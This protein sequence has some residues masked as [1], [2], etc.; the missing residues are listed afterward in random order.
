M[1]NVQKKFVCMLFYFVSIGLFLPFGANAE[2]AEV[3]F[4]NSGF[5]TGDFT[6]WF[7]GDNGL[8]ALNP[9]MVSTSTSSTSY[10]F[11]PS[12][13][14]SLVALNGFDGEA[15]YEAFLYQD[16]IV[17]AE[18]TSL[19][20][21]DRIVYDGMGIPS[22]LPRIYEVQVRD[23]NNII[24]EVLHHQEVMLNNQPFTDLGWQQRTFNLSQY[25]GQMVRIYINLY[26]PES[27]T[28][29]AQIEFDNFT[30]TNA[31]I[32]SEPIVP[33]VSGCLKLNGIPLANRIVE[34]FPMPLPPMETLTDNNGCYSFPTI[35]D[36]VTF[37]IIIK[38][39]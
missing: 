10:P 39:P 1:K 13:E 27:F 36:D 35:T 18:A 8:P 5:E 19:T 31:P 9:W 38:N 7:Y 15:G 11:D 34:I 22:S 16:I 20:F 2:V 6:G 28:G 12:G 29:P 26:V 37:D 25:A 4:V 3:P 14:G 17:P 23:T 32:C 21:Q 30:F 24:L 33:G